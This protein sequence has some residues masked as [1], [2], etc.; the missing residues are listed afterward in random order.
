[1]A[2]RA[3]LMDRVATYN[4]YG[5]QQARAALRASI[6]GRDKTTPPMHEVRQL[7][8]PGA[9]CD[10]PARL[11]RPET[12]TDARGAA[13]VY[14]HGGGF[15]LGELDTNDALCRRLCSAAGVT[16]IA[17]HYRLAPEAPFPAQLDDTLAAMRWIAD[18]AVALQID[19]DRIAISGDSAGAYL[20]IAATAVLNAERPGAVA[21]QILIYPLLHI[22]DGV[23]SQSVF[24]HARIVG[25]AAVAYIRSQLG[26]SAV[27]TPSL[28]VQDL[29]PPPPTL[30][31]MGGALDP[32]RPDAEAYARKI[33]AAGVR[34]VILEYPLLPHGFANLTHVSAASRKAMT[35][36]GEAAG[37]LL[38]ETD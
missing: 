6:A 3:E 34:P 33:E 38:R 23:W 11:Y 28:L 25:R 21:A 7:T 27:T 2:F 30:I 17:V 20:A 4:L 13:I 31:A 14:F 12:A 32:V 26:E 16:L 10:L 37:S 29:P 5:L 18:N 15:V 1:M 9:A 35:Q 36:I 8:I 24:K 22:D 19:P